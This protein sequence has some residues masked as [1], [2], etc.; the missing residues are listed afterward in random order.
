MTLNKPIKIV[1]EKSV[2]YVLR[3]IIILDSS[4]F[5]LIDNYEQAEVILFENDKPSYIRQ[6]TEFR[7]YPEKCMVVSEMDLPTYFL[8][9]CYASN[10]NFWLSRGRSKSIPY[11]MTQHAEPNHF[12]KDFTFTNSQRYL[13]SFKGG[14]T[15][16]IRKKL[17]K[18]NHNFSDVLIEESNHY[19]H[20]NYDNSYRDQKE[21]LMQQYAKLID[22]S[23]FFLCPRGAGVSSIRL[24]EVMQAGR[25]PVIISDDW[26]PIDGIPWDEFSIR[27]AEKDLQKL[28]QIVRSRE[29]DA[30]QLGMKA[31]QAWVSF[32]SKEVQSKLLSQAIIAIQSARNERR[33]TL[34]RFLFPLLEIK[35]NLTSKTVKLL[36]Y[37][38]LRAYALMGRKFPYS[39]NR[40]IEEQLRS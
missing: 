7:Q 8:P 21:N 17:F 33:E 13:Y 18:M 23:L 19:H 12:I 4:Q 10:R 14:S 15:S 28:D 24:F 34:L 37:S 11:I 22:E 30:K 20:W 36:K 2:G 27:I 6:T 1:L 26:I 38:I 31:R 29:H 9:A 35:N 25:V 3:D 5:Q 39:L 40:P 32:C 16:W